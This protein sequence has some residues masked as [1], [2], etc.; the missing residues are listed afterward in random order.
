MQL[1]DHL[2]PNI[3]ILLSIPCYASVFAYCAIIVISN[4]D[5]GMDWDD[6]VLDDF[7]FLNERKQFSRHKN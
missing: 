5:N 7:K 3:L 6:W 2:I 1:R 4:L